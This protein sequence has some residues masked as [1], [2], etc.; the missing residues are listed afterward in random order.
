MRI[1]AW[2]SWRA[3]AAGLFLIAGLFPTK[4][5][6][7]AESRSTFSI[8]FENDL[9]YH[10]DRDYTNGVEASWTPAKQ[11]SAFLPSLIKDSVL[12]LLG[13]AD[14]RPTYS[15][16]Q[17]MF[18]PEHTAL[19]VPPL[20]ERPYA[21][22]LYGGLALTKTIDSEQDQLQVR[23]GMIGPASLA[24]DSQRL[25]H[26]TRGLSFPQGWSTQLR[27]EPGLVIGYEKSRTV[28][29]LAAPDGTGLDLRAHL[30]G[31]VGNVF[32]YLNT[33]IMGR[34][35]YHMPSDDGPPRIEPS[36]PGSYSYDPNGVFGAYL[37]AGAEARLVGR[38]LFLDG[39]S[40]QS[41]RSVVKKPIVGDLVVGG[42]IAFEFFR[43]SFAHTFRSREYVQQNEFDE[44]GTLSLSVNL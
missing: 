24:A 34:V 42:A 15:V 43:L 3:A 21:G 17:L 19:T 13:L 2:V 22:F 44:F 37:F 1:L 25:V 14:A 35:G 10:T 29:A 28:M 39:N 20:N 31:T 41:S 9:F 32:D 40:F 7:A 12:P 8:I 36:A 38:N 26:S 4:P 18:T 23:L 16:G 30:G 27:D 5:A 33:G 6:S 11:E